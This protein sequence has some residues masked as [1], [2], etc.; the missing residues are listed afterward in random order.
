M[1]IHNE[2]VSQPIIKVATA[3]AAV[4]ITSWAEFASFLAAL[5]S[6]LLI[7]EW[8]WKRI[9]VPLRAKGVSNGRK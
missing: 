6:L 4:G 7:L 8:V 1:S 2:P 5:Y 9:I 3:W